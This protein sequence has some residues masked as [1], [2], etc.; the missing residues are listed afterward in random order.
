MLSIGVIPFVLSWLLLIGATRRRGCEGGIGR[1]FLCGS[2]LF[3]LLAAGLTEA[4]S[5]LGALA[6]TPLVAA[7]TLIAAGALVALRWTKRG[8]RAERAPAAR[9]AWPLL[10]LAG[11]VLLFLLG[12]GLVAAPNNWDSLTYHLPRA[13]RWLQS[14]SVAHYATDCTRQNMY[15]PLSEYF[16]AQ[17]MCLTGADRGVNVVQACGLLGCAVAASLLTRRLRGRPWAQALA[18]VF[19]VTAP[20]AVLQA[21]SPKN[22]LLAAFFLLS[23][24]YFAFELCEHRVPK[25]ESALLFGAAL[26]L[27]LLT[28]ATAYVFAAPLILAVAIVCFARQGRGAVFVRVGAPLAALVLGLN[29]P[30]LLRNWESYGVLLGPPGATNELPTPAALASVMARNLGLHAF[31][32]QFPGRWRLPGLLEATHRAALGLDLNDPRTTWPLAS[33]ALPKLPSLHEDDAGCPIHVALIGLALLAL[34]T[35]RRRQIAPILYASGLVLAFVLFS[36]ALRWQPWGVRLMI[37]LV[38]A[39]A[40]LAARMLEECGPWTRRVAIVGLVAAAVPCLLWNASRPACG[41]QSVFSTPRE[42]QYFVNRAAL[43]A[44]YAAALERIAALKPRVVGLALSEDSFE[45]PLWRFVERRLPGARLVT[46]Q[47]D[48]RVPPHEPRQPWV[49]FC[50]SSQHAARLLASGWRPLAAPSAGE[51]S[52]WVA[53]G[54]A[55]RRRPAG[56]E[57]SPQGARHDEANRTSEDSDSPQVTSRSWVARAP[58]ASPARAADRLLERALPPRW[59]LGAPYATRGF[60]PWVLPLRRSAAHTRFRGAHA[61]PRRVRRSAARAS[62]PCRAA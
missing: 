20:T 58:E 57:M 22:D 60:T 3:A 46:L 30:P 43:G 27:A 38:L 7:W 39:G 16:V 40:P 36:A 53:P 61:V 12:L 47:M 2:V 41:P 52:A 45:Y 62:R 24:A 37:P 29:A 21:T 28:K 42:R 26:A 1:A 5:A 32:P 8:C 48:A 25:S 55:E 23:A 56:A 19:V 11:A 10:G 9:D 35:R 49:A 13:M 44:P 6:Y 33:F 59:G 50:A 54:V 14:H 17:I 34:A 18:A 51:V 31:V 4:L 15:P